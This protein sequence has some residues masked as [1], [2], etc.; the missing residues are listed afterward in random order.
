MYV[1][2]QKGDRMLKVLGKDHN[3]PIQKN[4]FWLGQLRLMDL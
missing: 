1:M 3:F 2:P 4:V